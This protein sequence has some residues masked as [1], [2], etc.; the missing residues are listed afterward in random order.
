ME[1]TTRRVVGRP[2][3]KGVSPNPKGRPPRHIERDYIGAAIGEVSLEEW[4]GVVRK[5]KEQALKGD[6]PA[7][8]WLG[9]IL[10][11]DDP[12]IIVQ[13]NG[14][15][16]EMIARVEER[17]QELIALKA[18]LEERLARVPQLADGDLRTASESGTPLS[19]GYLPNT[20]HPP[21][22]VSGSGDDSGPLATQGG[23][24][25]LF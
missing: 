6:A 24:G 8:N 14:E 5:A 1:P 23:D 20:T 15:L 11:G 7:R 19:L 3:V 18:E 9:K 22:T 13:I 10:I 17:E 12:L 25:S 4:R 21:G 16:R 2:F